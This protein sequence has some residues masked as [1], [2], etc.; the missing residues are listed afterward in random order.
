MAAIAKLFGTVFALILLGYVAFFAVVNDA[1][2]P[3]T[4]VPQS[5]PIE[6]PIWLVAL[7]A[8][9]AGLLIVALL[10][11][12]RISA[13]RLQLYRTEKKLLKKLAKESSNARPTANTA[14]ES[15]SFHEK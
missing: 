15:L 13:L 2:I 1:I 3:L 5:T 14:T 10:A 9:C 8:F 4:L 7:C 11:S 12:I 6:A